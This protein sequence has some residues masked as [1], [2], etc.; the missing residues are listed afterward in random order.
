M[1]APFYYQPRDGR[2]RVAAVVLYCDDGWVPRAASV[3]HMYVFAHKY[4]IK[5]LRDAALDSVA[6]VVVWH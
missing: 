3:V 1:T 6:D 4:L 5:D 2:R